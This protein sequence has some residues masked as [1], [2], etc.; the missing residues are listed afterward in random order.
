MRY[1]LIP[2]NLSP[3]FVEKPILCLI[4][5]TNTTPQLDTAIPYCLVARTARHRHDSKFLLKLAS[6]TPPTR[7]ALVKGNLWLELNDQFSTSLVRPAIHEFTILG[8]SKCK[9][10][11]LALHT[12]VCL[13]SLLFS[14]RAHLHVSLQAIRFE[15]Q[16]R[17]LIVTHP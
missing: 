4:F 16:I 14:L 3:V 2:E 8:Q 11:N 7:R 5:G 6:P 17:H 12:S 9:Y 13:M 10:F 15:Y 1:S